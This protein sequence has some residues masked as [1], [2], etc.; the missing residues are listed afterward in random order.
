MALI[1]SFTAP[2]DGNDREHTDP[3]P[4]VI[5]QLIGLPMFVLPCEA[6][7]SVSVFPTF[8]LPEAG[9]AS[10]AVWFPGTRL[11]VTVLVAGPK[12]LPPGLAAVT[13]HVPVPE[14]AE[15]EP[16][17]IVHGPVV[18]YVSGEPDAVDDVNVS[19]VPLG[20]E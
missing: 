14:L 4:L 5:F 9:A 1:F 10:L 11:T 17:L 8:T 7:A 2:L 6:L 12:P 20:T 18:E 15:N 3:L 16:A 19:F 13:R